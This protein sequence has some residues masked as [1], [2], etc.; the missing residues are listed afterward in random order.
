MVDELVT[1]QTVW[2]VS[3]AHFAQSRLEEADIVA[4]LE[5]EYAVMMTPHMANPSGIKLNV[6]RCDA[7]A[8]LEVLAPQK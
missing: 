3:A 5:N 4:F 7:Q 2:N 1:V 8:A 6:K